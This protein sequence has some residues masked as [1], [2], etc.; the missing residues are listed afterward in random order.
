MP[1]ETDPVKQ[2][3][4][5]EKIFKVLDANHNET[6]DKKK[7]GCSRESFLEGH[8]LPD[9]DSD[10]AA[11]HERKP[12]AKAVAQLSFFDALNADGDCQ[13]TLG[14][15][16]TVITTGALPDSAYP[17]MSKLLLLSAEFFSQACSDQRV[18]YF[19]DLG[20]FGLIPQSG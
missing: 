5:S 15:W 19:A 20:E 1:A 8:P 9:E 17:H 16:H 11:R 7:Y 3:Q 4:M 13:V 10:D 18:V 6:L 12:R 2:K 14:E